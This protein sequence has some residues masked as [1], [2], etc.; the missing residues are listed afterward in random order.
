MREYCINFQTLNGSF[1]NVKKKLRKN[2][3]CIL[4]NVIK[5][6]DVNFMKS[7]NSTNEKRISGPWKYKMKD[8][9]RLDLGDSYKN[10]RFS[11]CITFCEWNKKNEKFYKIIRPVIEIRNLLSK[12]KKEKYIYK[13]LT[14]FQKDHNKDKIFCD[15]VRMLQY[16]TGGGFLALHDDF[17]KNY[18]ERILNAILTVTSRKKINRN[19]KLYSY[20][21]GGLY[22]LKNKKKINVEN[23]MNP[24]D[25]ILF[26][27]KIPHGVNSVDPHEKITLDNLNGR[28]S[29][30]FSIG[31]FLK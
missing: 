15:F 22:F 9:R 16:P 14:P 18:P 2:S 12:V 8:I 30:A 20:K 4:K 21:V 17:D 10:S 26:D 31:R 23:M 5:E 27:Q 3:F 29:L 13:D 6:K 25:L 7:F 1:A 24:G 11:R 28:I 19:S